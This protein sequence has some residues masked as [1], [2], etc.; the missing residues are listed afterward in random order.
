[1]GEAAE[2]HHFVPVHSQKDM[3]IDRAVHVLHNALRCAPAAASAPAFRASVPH[4]RHSSGVG[5]IVLHDAD[6]PGSDCRTA[7]HCFFPPDISV[8]L[9]ILTLP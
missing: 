9:S 5:M 7:F 8:M 3:K 2:S 1:M 6:R 4:V